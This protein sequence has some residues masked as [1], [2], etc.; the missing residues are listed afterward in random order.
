M[1][2]QLGMAP[3]YRVG[4]STTDPAVNGRPIVAEQMDS[5]QAQ[6]GIKLSWWRGNYCSSSEWQQTVVAKIQLRMV[7][8]S[9]ERRDGM[10]NPAWHG[11]RLP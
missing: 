9:H 11:T 1:T 4:K 7:P 2:G 6:N 5:D 10:T 3:N 8:G